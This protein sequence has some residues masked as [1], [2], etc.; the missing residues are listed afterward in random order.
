MKV[1]ELIGLP[2]FA[3]E[4]AFA[5]LT[6]NKSWSRS[7]GSWPRSQVILL[8]EP[9]AGL[10]VTMIDRMVELIFQLKKENR[11]VILVDTT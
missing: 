11:T 8:D 6:A 9:M 10:S 3:N 1:L 4:Y 7:A 5:L 2:D